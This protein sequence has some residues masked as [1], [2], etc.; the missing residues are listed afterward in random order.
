M[1]VIIMLSQVVH[2]HTKQVMVLKE[3]QRFDQQSRVSFVKEACPK[4]N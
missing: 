3:L 1:P 2:K 4:R